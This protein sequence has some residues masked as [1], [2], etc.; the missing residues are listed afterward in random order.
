MQTISMMNWSA[1]PCKRFQGHDPHHTGYVCSHSWS[2]I[3][4]ISPKTTKR[5]KSY[6]S[7]LVV[8]KIGFNKKKK[9]LKGKRAVSKC[10]L[11]VFRRKIR[12]TLVIY[13]CQNVCEIYTSRI[14][15]TAFLSDKDQEINPVQ[16]RAEY[17][18]ISVKFT[19]LL[20]SL[21]N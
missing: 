2:L 8:F 3:S 18:M 9:T 20:K 16:Q 21:E 5:S 11:S 12:I 7:G 17:L 19:I 14:Q 13:C 4:P 15:W 10:I 6:T 1:G